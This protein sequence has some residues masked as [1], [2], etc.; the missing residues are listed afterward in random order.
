MKQESMRFNTSSKSSHQIVGDSIFDIIFST[1][2]I[3]SSSYMRYKSSCHRK[4]Y[5][6][7]SDTEKYQDQNLYW[8]SLRAAC[9]HHIYET[10]SC[11]GAFKMIDTCASLHKTLLTSVSRQPSNMTKGKKLLFSWNSPA[12]IRSRSNVAYLLL[13]CTPALITQSIPII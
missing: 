1:L 13:L 7:M 3:I 8:I 2:E 4:S 6:N 9:I 11:A 5:R 10:P 12:H